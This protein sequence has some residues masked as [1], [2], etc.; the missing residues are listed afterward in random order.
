MDL[1]PGADHLNPLNLIPGIAT[2]VNNLYLGLTNITNR[3]NWGGNTTPPRSADQS[4]LSQT[5]T[6]ASSPASA[7]SSFTVSA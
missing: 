6:V 5:Q 7:N 1:T 4:N 2:N 3:G